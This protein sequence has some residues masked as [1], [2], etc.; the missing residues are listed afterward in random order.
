MVYAFVNMARHVLSK[1]KS[2]NSFYV[3]SEFDMG[4]R[5]RRER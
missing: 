5:E 3:S 4:E 1:A 2:I